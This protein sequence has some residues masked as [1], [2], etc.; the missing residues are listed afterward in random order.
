MTSPAVWAFGSALGVSLASLVG[1]AVLPLGRGRHRDVTPGLLALGAG[2]LLGNAG[3][4]LLP[5]ALAASRSLVGPLVAFT[6][7]LLGF[8]ALDG[9]IHFVVSRRGSDGVHSVGYVN[10]LADAVHNLVDGVAMA[11][12]Y[13]VDFELGVATTLAVLAHEVPT[14][15]GDFAI[16]LDAGFSRR[17]ALALNL[18][19]GFAAIAG[20]ALAWLLG[21]RVQSFAT[22]ALPI[23]AGGFVYIAVTHLLPRLLRRR[24]PLD[25]AF[26]GA[27]LL[28]ML[29]L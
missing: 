3:L 1:V 6:A 20:V 15:L 16:L 29:V 24:V 26:L 4:H 10:L 13:S 25:L 17:R 21:Q 2:A 11:V 27:G 14:E 5:E 22:T 7:S 18:L 28:L 8:A 12:A 19:S 9:A 23:V